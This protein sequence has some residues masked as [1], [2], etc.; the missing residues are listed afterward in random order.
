MYLF[1]DLLTL[2][3]CDVDIVTLETVSAVWCLIYCDQL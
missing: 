2:I 3:K 1:L